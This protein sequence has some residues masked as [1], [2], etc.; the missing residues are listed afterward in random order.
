MKRLFPIVFLLVCSYSIVSAQSTVDTTTPVVT[1]WAE[2]PLPEF[3]GGDEQLIKF[4]QENTVYPKM[5]QDSGIQ[6][7]VIVRFFVEKD[8]SI[9]EINVIRKVSP[10]L[11]AEAVRVVKSFPE[12]IAARDYKHEPVRVAYN[13]PFNFKLDDKKK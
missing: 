4:L 6:G 3:P 1:T 7:K 9:S 5:E 12:F 2:R 11:D 8:G 13:L 10:G